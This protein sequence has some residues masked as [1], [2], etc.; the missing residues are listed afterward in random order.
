MEVGANDPFEGS[1]TWHLEQKGWTG[2]LVEPNPTLAEKLKEKRPGSK[3]VQCACT[4][5]EKTGALTLHIHESHGFSSTERNIDEVNLEY[6]SEVKV[7]GKTLEVLLE[8]SK[9][10]QVHFMSIDVEG[11]EL[12]VLRGLNL[13]RR[14]LDFL[15]LEDKLH[16]LSKHRYLKRHGYRLV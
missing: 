8:E 7:M 3:V 15:L 11:T 16:N 9:V 13:D 14:R 12:D 6:A 1:Q 10:G 4:A 5:P 2:L